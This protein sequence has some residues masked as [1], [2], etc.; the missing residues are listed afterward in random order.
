MTDFFAPREIQ[1]PSG[2][3]GD[4]QPA[5]NK[6]RGSQMPVER[7]LTFAEEVEDIQL[8]GRTWPD[9]KITSAPQWCAVDLRDGN[10]AL[11]D[12]MSPER[13]RRMFN[14]LVETGFKE[15][16]VGFPSAS[17]TDFDFVREIIEKDMIPDDVTIQV[18]VQA[19]E[20]LIRRTFEACAGAKNVIVHFY[21]STSK[22][23]R[24]AVFRKDRDAIK[25]L[26]TDAAALI[27][28]IAADYP[29]TNWRWEYSPESFT[30]TELDFAKEVCDAVVDVMAPTPENPMIIN[31]P[32]TVEMITPNVYADS[33]E[34]MHRNLNNRESIII[35]L[36]PHNDR[37][38]GVAAAELGYMAGG[39]RIEGCLFGNGER[40]GNVDLVTLGLNMLTQGVDPQIDFSDITR[41]R[42]VVEYCNQLRVPERHPYGGDLVFTA[43]SGSHQD[44]INKGLDAL[45]QTVR[46]DATS[47]DVT[48]EELSETTWEVPYL[49]ID[50]KDVGRTYEAVIRVNSQSGK[51]GVA[52]IM[53]TDHGINM[54]RAMQPEFS[55]IVQNI[56]DSEGGE[57]NSKNMWDVFATTYL[58]LDSP[59]ELAHY[60]IDAAEEEGQDTRVAAT[61]AY[62]GAS[63]E[64]AGTGNGPIAAFA[65]ALEQVGIDFEVQD[66]SQR[67]RTAGDD[68]DAVCYIHADVD[69]TS[70]WGVGIAGSTTRASLEAIVSAVNRS[71]AAN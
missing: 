62:E 71:T 67:A 61:V 31:L 32:S 34:W 1:T 60:R 15:I 17:Q 54:P 46:P 37:G 7:Y 16:E 9:K 6:Q 53:K 38:T 20:H 45:A 48:W 4:G 63:R 56:T 27:K 58:D 69:G 43:F 30:G 2:P 41:I 35:S 14:L 3:R 22:L 47:S 50:P 52:Y 5:W 28:T 51:G 68:A 23:Q 44:A 49:P 42:E 10:Q 24:R 40:T 65:N 57:V 21:N 19:R 64:V 33:I 26:A 11:I 55:A 59:L 36:H 12:P 39:D 18:L 8:P 29:D 13:K 70:A 25:K 66:Y